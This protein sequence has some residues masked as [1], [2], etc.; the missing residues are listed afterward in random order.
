[1]RFLNPFLQSRRITIILSILLIFTNGTL[2]SQQILRGTVKD[3]NGAPL[4]GATVFNKM[5]NKGAVSDT[6]GHF[7]IKADS[8]ALIEISFIGYRN[9]QFTVS[10]NRVL[11]ITL[12]DTTTNWMK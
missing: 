7:T 8:G 12:S 11:N 9:Q 1:M 10:N 5:T 3:R 2:Y 4:I 6:S